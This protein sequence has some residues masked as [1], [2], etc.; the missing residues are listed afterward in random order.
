MFAAPRSSFGNWG[1]QLGSKPL[2]YAVFWVPW[3]RSPKVP[4]RSNLPSF[5]RFGGCRGAPDPT[6]LVLQ[7]LGFFKRM[8]KAISWSVPP[9][10]DQWSWV[11]NTKICFE[12]LRRCLERP[13]TKSCYNVDTRGLVWTCSNLSKLVQIVVRNNEPMHCLSLVDRLHFAYTNDMRERRYAY[14]RC[15]IKSTFEGLWLWIYLKGFLSSM[16]MA[17][18]GVSMP[19][20][21]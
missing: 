11:I 20:C 15:S 21:L 1:F 4:F 13:D 6:A 3:P 18:V 19:K 10:A 16:C 9:R 17:I 5:R 7:E 12:W 8:P 14:Q 2:Y